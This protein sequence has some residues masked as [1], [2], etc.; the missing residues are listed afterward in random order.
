VVID[1]VGPDVSPGQTSRHGHIQIPMH[2]D[3]GTFNKLNDF[4]RALGNYNTRTNR[5]ALFDTSGNLLAGRVPSTT[6]NTDLFKV[7]RTEHMDA[8]S[9]FT[10]LKASF[11]QA[12]VG[13]NNQYLATGSTLEQWYL[14]RVTD[15]TNVQGLP[16]TFSSTDKQNAY[17]LRNKGTTNLYMTAN[18][19]N[20]G[21]FSQPSFY[22]LSQA[23]RSNPNWATQIWVREPVG[24]GSYRF[25]SAWVPAADKNSAS[26]AIYLTMD[27]NASDTGTQ[28]VYVQVKNDTLD[29]Q[30]WLIE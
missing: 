28:N 19:V 27:R 2:Y 8:S 12:D 1:Y 16:A 26:V 17:R 22:V 10:Y 20:H 23:L 9:Q 21:T 14:E 13:I 6:G 3:S 15:F 24:N 11:P 7:L 30:H 25:R 5:V 4:S 18:D 29:R